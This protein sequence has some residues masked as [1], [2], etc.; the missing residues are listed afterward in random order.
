MP[1]IPFRKVLAPL[2]GNPAISSYLTR[3]FASQ[4]HDWFAFI[5]EES[6]TTCFFELD[7]KA[8]LVPNVFGTEFVN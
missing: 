5:G 2:F 3:G 8:R 6:E 1:D 7:G 4:P